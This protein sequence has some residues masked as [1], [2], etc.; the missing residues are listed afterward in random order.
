M[1]DN[2]ENYNNANSYLA[3]NNII[4][5][6][7]AWIIVFGSTL[8]FVIR[9]IS[10]ESFLFMEFYF[11]M[12]LWLLITLVSLITNCIAANTL[13]KAYYSSQPLN[14][15][16]VRKVSKDNI[17][18]SFNENKIGIKETNDKVDSIS[19]RQT[20]KYSHIELSDEYEKKV[21]AYGGKESQISINKDKLV[22]VGKNKRLIIN[23]ESIYL[24]NRFDNNENSFFDIVFSVSE[25]SF[26]MVRFYF[27]KSNESNMI[28]AYL[29]R[30]LPAGVSNIDFTDK[31]SEYKK[32]GYAGKRYLIVF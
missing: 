31:I 17:S 7:L 18:E 15:E 6:I 28:E 30:L 5:S 3:K 25:K 9:C 16:I 19:N 22:L 24:V 21:Y 10:T 11:V 20:K 26:S 12:I 2:R 32:N 29:E 27:S 1:N 23:K 8:V 14:Q 4:T 13:N